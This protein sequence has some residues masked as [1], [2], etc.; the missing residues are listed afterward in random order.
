M[1]INSVY[2]NSFPVPGLF[3]LV[4]CGGKSCRMGTDKSRLCYFD[5]PQCYHVYELLSPLCEKVYIS[6]NE[7]Q[8][9]WIDPQYE[10]IIDLDYYSDLGPMSGL[11]TALTGF[12][13]NNFLMAGCDYPF[14]QQ[15]DLAEL[16]LLNKH[17]NSAA[18]YNEDADIYEP[19]LAYYSHHVKKDLMEMFKAGNYSLRDFLKTSNAARF[20]PKDKGS[21]RSIDTMKEFT[22]TKMLLNKDL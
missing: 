1:A 5:K 19:V 4:T 15:A 2:K 9:E 6:C 13:H 3:G 20:Y 14:L 21:V 8:A 17:E 16:L 7:Q 18:F 10:T 22:E 11:L 12:P